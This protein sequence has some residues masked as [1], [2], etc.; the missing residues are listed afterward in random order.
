[1][2]N[3]IL[4]VTLLIINELLIMPNKFTCQR[5]PLSVKGLIFLYSNT[6]HAWLDT[7]MSLVLRTKLDTENTICLFPYLGYGHT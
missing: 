5:E 4:E 7:C 2:L 3:N 1:M 6:T